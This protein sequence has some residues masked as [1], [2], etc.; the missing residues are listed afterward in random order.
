MAHR[1]LIVARGSG[2]GCEGYRC[3]RDG[4]QLLGPSLRWHAYQLWCCAQVN[5]EDTDLKPIVLQQAIPELYFKNDK[6]GGTL[7]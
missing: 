6:V 5:T 3:R 2:P 7:G 4:A 1:K